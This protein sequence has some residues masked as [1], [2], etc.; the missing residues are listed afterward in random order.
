MKPEQIVQKWGA[1]L[2]LIKMLD[3]LLGCYRLGTRPS[4]AM[5]DQIRRL[6]KE[7]AEETELQPLAD[8]IRA[9]QLEHAALGE[10]GKYHGAEHEEDCPCDDTCD[11]KHKEFNARINDAYRAGETALEKL[12]SI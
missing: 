4:G 10:I 5:L 11:C 8:L 2:E 6:R 7:V 1:T 9:A 12:G 3:R